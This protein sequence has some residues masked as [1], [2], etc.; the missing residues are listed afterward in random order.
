MAA[1]TIMLAG[2]A[3]F[4]Y[5][6]A[7]LQSAAGGAGTTAHPTTAPSNDEQFDYPNPKPNVGA[8]IHVLLEGLGADST[9]MSGTF[10]LYGWIPGAAAGVGAWAHLID[11][12]A[13]HAISQATQPQAVVDSTHIRY[14]EQVNVSGV[15]TA[16]KVRS[17]A[18]ANSTSW[19]PAIGAVRG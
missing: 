2:L 7:L 10:A 1:A 16:Y 15:C 12:N 14:I 17:L 11:L 3:T 8:T 4:R 9:T 6:S 19:T 18:M 13:G 5:L